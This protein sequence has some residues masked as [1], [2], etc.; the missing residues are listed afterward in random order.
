MTRR[1]RRSQTG[2]PRFGPPHPLSRRQDN[3]R[4]PDRRR[5]SRG[6]TSRCRWRGDRPRRDEGRAVDRLFLSQ[7]RYRGLHDARRRT[8]ARRRPHSMH[9]HVQVARASR[10]MHGEALCKFAR[11]VRSDRNV[12]LPT[13]TARC[14]KHSAPGSKNRIYGRKYMGIDRST[15]LFGPD[16][17]LVQSMAQGAREGVMSR[18]CWRLRRIWAAADADGGRKPPARSC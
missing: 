6:Q 8:S 5:D 18:R 15:F 2:G 9:L 10:A 17:K 7:G 16:G 13:P 12:L 11:Q 4:P 1:G 3:E 14:W